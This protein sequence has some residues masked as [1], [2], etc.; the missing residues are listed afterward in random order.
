[1]IQEHQNMTLRRAVVF[2]ALMQNGEGLPS[3]SADYVI[4]KWMAIQE[5]SEP[6]VLLDAPNMAR[7]VAWYTAWQM[8]FKTPPFR[9]P[10]THGGQLPDLLVQ[11]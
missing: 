6:E 2:A 7:V 9:F 4:E 11:P 8:A 1:M 10:M 5:L 3:K